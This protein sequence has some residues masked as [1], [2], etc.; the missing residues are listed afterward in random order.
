MA[1]IIRWETPFTEILNPSVGLTIQT[2]KDGTDILTAI[3]APHGVGLYPKFLV[4]FGEVVAFTC[5]EEAHAPQ[6]DFNSAIFEESNICSY[7]YLD[8]PWL[9]SYDGWQNF[10]AG[11]KFDS[12]SH[13]MIFGGDNNI[14]VITPNV[15]KIEI[16]EDKTVLKFEIEI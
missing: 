11:G 3:V 16:V 6:R 8:S 9:L 12:F 15:P 13:Y 1:K 5:F 7:Q 2:L 10:F 14:E 4:Q